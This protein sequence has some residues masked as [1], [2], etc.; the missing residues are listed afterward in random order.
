MVCSVL[1]F[2]SA[3]SLCYNIG[4]DTSFLSTVRWGHILILKLSGASVWFN[5]L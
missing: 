1:V 3:T 4:Q 5:K 2:A